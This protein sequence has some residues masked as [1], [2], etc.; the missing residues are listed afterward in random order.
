MTG[1][2]PALSAWEADVLPLNYIRVR[3]SA[4][5][6]L[7]SLP[8][9]TGTGRLGG[10]LLTDRGSGV[11]AWPGS[12][13][14]PGQAARRLLQRVET[15]VPRRSEE[16]SPRGERV[17][18]D[19]TIRVLRVAHGDNSIGCCYFRTV[20]VVHASSCLTPVQALT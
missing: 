17:T 19:G 7:A 4:G 11:A 3:A 1:I 8:H 10:V 14:V 9:R 13:H 2:E 15:A 5:A 6:G 18:Q 16:R 12:P 20:P